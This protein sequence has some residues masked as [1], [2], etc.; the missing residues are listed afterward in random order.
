VKGEVKTIA[1]FRHF[2]ISY[3]PSVFIRCHVS[4]E[5]G[6]ATDEAADEADT[7]VRVATNHP[8]SPTRH[9]FHLFLSVAT[10]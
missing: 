8:A 5:E 9:L 4:I 7:G 10:F 2:L 3:S 1:H 6:L